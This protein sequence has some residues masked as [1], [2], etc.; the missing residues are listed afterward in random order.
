MGQK[1]L[2]AVQ[3]CTAT[4]YTDLDGLAPTLGF[5]GSSR[6]LKGAHRISVPLKCC[7]TQT[8]FDKRFHTRAELFI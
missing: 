3:S 2:S 8:A 7:M 4:L 1:L 5:F 6:T